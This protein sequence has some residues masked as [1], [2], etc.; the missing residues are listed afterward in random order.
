MRKPIAKTSRGFTLV[1][2]LVVITIIGILVALLLPAVQAAR[3]AARRAQ[4]LNHLKQLALGFLQHEE[5]HK[6]LPTGGW[7]FVMVG[8]PNRGFDKHQPGGWNYNVLP[9]IEQQALYDLGNGLTGVALSSAN[10][11]RVMTPLAVMN[12]PTRRLPVV[13]ALNPS[14]YSWNGQTGAMYMQDPVPGCARSD[15]AANAGDTDLVYQWLGPVPYATG[16][17]PG[18]PWP[19]PSNY[20][21]I[22]FVRSE[23]KIAD[24]TDG[25]SNTY[26]VGEKYLNSDLYFTGTDPADDQSMYSGFNNDNS[27]SSDPVYGP[28][29]QDMPGYSNEGL[30]GSAHA[31]GFNMAFCDG[32]V[33]S[34]NYSIDPEIHRRLGNR[35]DGLTIDAKDL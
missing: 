35:H 15:Y 32:S 5:N 33:H 23:I 11:Q 2:L 7:S 26:M 24:I 27:R 17:A 14:H 6:I 21:G 10:A 29:S 9:F 12:C 13:L 20:T 28:P 31:E 4:C 3:E 8:D 25:T 19:S 34:I 18:Y 30:W 1:E 16:D 22:Q